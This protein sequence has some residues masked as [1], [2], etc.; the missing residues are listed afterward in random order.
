MTLKNDTADKLVQNKSRQEGEEQHQEAKTRNQ[1]EDVKRSYQSVTAGEILLLLAWSPVLWPTCSICAQTYSQMLS[2]D[3]FFICALKRFN[4]A[5]SWAKY[6]C[7][8]E[9]SS[10]FTVR[11]SS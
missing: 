10:G 8:V 6:R 2:E 3:D 4:L 9:A 5:P 1:S 11:S 7:R